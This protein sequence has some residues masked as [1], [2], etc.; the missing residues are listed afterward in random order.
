MIAHGLAATAVAVEKRLRLF[1]HAVLVESEQPQWRLPL[2]VRG[3]VL[4]HDHEGLRLV[5]PV[6]PLE[7]EIADDVARVAFV[8]H[9]LAV[10]DHR[11]VVVGALA[12]QDVPVVV[13]HGIA[14]EV[15]F[16]DDGRL[17]AALLK[18]RRESG[19]GAVKA[20]VAVVVEAV[21][22]RVLAGL[23]HRAAGAAD[24]VR[25][26]AAVKA[27]ALFGDAVHVRRF[28]QLAAVAI[29]ADG[30]AGQ[31]VA[32]NEDNV[33]RLGGAGGDRKG[34]GGE[35]GSNHDCIRATVNLEAVFN[36]QPL[37]SCLIKTG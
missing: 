2:A 22:V 15:P 13:A 14:A 24:G 30:L 10:V 11:R 9:L 1:I 12:R 32:E 29:A 3:L 5:A 16:S 37:A 7:R 4:A 8:L 28:E 23:D 19:L 33:R 25:D 18:H 26:E 34:E 27:H 6:E 21:G 35:Q 20:A 36:N 31:V 17:V